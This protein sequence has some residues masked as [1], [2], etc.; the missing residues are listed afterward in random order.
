MPEWQK[1]SKVIH[2]FLN[3]AAHTTGDAYM[4]WR[5]KTMIAAGIFDVQ[6]ELKNMKDFEVKTKAKQ[7][8]AAP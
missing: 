4:L 3:K 2:N 8:E 1:G 7:A 5:L 6:G